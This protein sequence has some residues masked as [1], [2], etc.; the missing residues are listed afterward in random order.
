MD[1]SQHVA[2]TPDGQSLLALQRDATVLLSAGTGR[3]SARLA[4][5]GGMFTTFVTSSDRRTL[6]QAIDQTHVRVLAWTGSTYRRLRD[7][8]VAGLI[9]DLA[10]NADG[11]AVAVADFDGQLFVADTTTGQQRTLP[12]QANTWASVQVTPDGRLLRHDNTDG[13]LEAFDVPSAALIG[14]WTYKAQP[15]GTENPR[16]HR[17]GRT[18]SCAGPRA[19]PPR[20]TCTPLSAGRI[21]QGRRG[22]AVEQRR[23]HR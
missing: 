23:S 8:S 1:G 15:A 6:V 10:L 9:R 16:G 5:T 2:F 14:S 11:T 19:T 7:I 4:G 3:V 12:G 17:P 20:Q 13:R 22:H 18:R 21:R